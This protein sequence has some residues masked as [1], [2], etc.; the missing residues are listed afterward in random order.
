MTVSEDPVAHWLGDRLI[1]A[2]DARRAVV[3]SGPNVNDLF[4]DAGEE[5]F[6]YVGDVVKYAHADECRSA[7]VCAPSGVQQDPVAG[8]QAVTLRLPAADAPPGLAVNTVRNQLLAISQP[9]VV[10]VDYADFLLPESGLTAA[11]S[12]DQ[13]LLLEALAS[14]PTDP[15]LSAHRLVLIARADSL[16]PRLARL[17]GFEVVIAELPDAAHRSQMAHRIIERNSV[18]PTEIAALEPGLSVDEL[19]TISGG[20]TNDDLMRGA[21]AAARRGSTLTRSWVQQTKVAR[22]R[23]RNAEGLEV[24]PPGR[25]MD[26]VAG[27]PQIRLFI[28]ERQGRGL[29]WPRA[30]V[31]AGPPGTGKTLVVTAIAD[32]LGWPALALGNVRSMWQGESERI[33]RSVLAT[34]QAM[35]PLVLHIDEVDQAI[36]QRQ[37]G[38]STDGGV[39]ARLMADLWTFLGDT[40]ADIPV[41]FVLTTNRPDL[42][43]PALRSRAEI[44]PLL[45]PGPSEQVDVLCIAAEEL[46]RPVAPEIAQRVLGDVDPGLV[47]GRILVRLAQRAAVLSGRSEGPLS[48]EHLRQAIAQLLE[49]VDEIEDERMAL[50]SIELAS[51]STYLPWIAARDL[52][53]PV[54]VPGYVAP[55]LGSDGTPDRGRLRARIAELD[56]AAH[57]RRAAQR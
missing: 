21:Q 49:R 43:D 36:G 9:V 57:Q 12:Q 16:D 20:L 1:R 13:V 41:L 11:P 18:V 14:F 34:A 39:G 31:L 33:M 4:W 40:N 53:E 17:P 29:P 6:Q 55:L 46:R 48:E 24:Y 26:G 38:P 30:L 25:G 37:T 5:R 50:K 52:D 45:H 3:I 56:R 15:R 51:F 28:H 22:I 32:T 27:L 35:A 42:L 23:H 54:H 8:L 19:A 7:V 10:I 44:I 2:A 47:S